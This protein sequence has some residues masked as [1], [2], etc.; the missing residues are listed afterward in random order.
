MYAWHLLERWYSETRMRQKQQCNGSASETSRPTNSIRR[1]MQVPAQ[2]PEHAGTRGPP[3]PR[4]ITTQAT[5]W[6]FQKPG[7]LIWTPKS[8]GP[9]TMR[10]PTTGAHNLQKRPLVYRAAGL[11]AEP[12]HTS[13][14][15]APAT[16]SPN[17]ESTLCKDRV[18]LPT[19]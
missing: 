14:S 11:W 1:N 4:V 12:R 5:T 3:G 6:G 19:A 10:T 17:Q 8:C 7:A 15:W 18:V 16:L 13:L 9:L 2:S